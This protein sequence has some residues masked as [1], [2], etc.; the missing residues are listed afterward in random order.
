MTSPT[1]NE[2]LHQVQIP[3][4]SELFSV[5]MHRCFSGDADKVPV[6]GSNASGTCRH[7]RPTQQREDK[8]ENFVEK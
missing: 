5:I 1:G 2:A 6:D 3:L 8:V 4:V 7:E